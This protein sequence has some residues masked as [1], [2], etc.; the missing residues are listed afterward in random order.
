MN[1]RNSVKH[2]IMHS[3]V[4]QNKASLALMSVVLG[5]GSPAQASGMTA[6]LIH[7]CTFL[8]IRTQGMYR[9]VWYSAELAKH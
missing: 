5:L 3:T 2:P 4:P 1:T 9:G 6:H 7:D 8:V